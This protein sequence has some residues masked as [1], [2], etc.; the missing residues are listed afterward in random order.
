[1]TVKD[2]PLQGNLFASGPVAIRRDPTFERI[3]LGH[4]AWV[5][6]ARGWLEGADEVAARLIPSVDWRLH[7]RWMYDRTVV[8]P[9]L[10]R[11]FGANDPLPDEALVSFRR[12]A[13]SHYGIEFAAMGLNYY[14]DGSDSVAFHADR[15]L[16]S[17]DSTLV[18][19]LT[20]GAERPF[21]LRPSGGGRSVDLSPASG[22]LLVMGGTCQMRWEHAVPKVSCAP[23]PRV[24][25]SLRWAKTGG[26]ELKWT[27]RDRTEAA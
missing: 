20:I 3:E 15:E 26:A 27:P 18:A 10:S 2:V 22:D 4:G 16:K 25:A 24:S 13:G 5:E 23:G 19:I 21:L 6:V 14:R 7:R 8:E 12:N 17:L 11:W 1:M 9:R